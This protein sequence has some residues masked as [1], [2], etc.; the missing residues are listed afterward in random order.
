MLIRILPLITIIVVLGCS[1]T[2]PRGLTLEFWSDHEAETIDIQPDEITQ[3]RIRDDGRRPAV[4]IILNER[5]HKILE[6]L[7]RTNLGKRVTIKSN[8]E[9]LFE[10]TIVVPINGGDMALACSSKDQAE[11]IIHK[12]GRQAVYYSTKPTPEELEEAKA[13]TE[14][15]KDPWVDK[16]IEADMHGDYEKAEEYARKAIELSPEKPTPHDF[17]AI[18]YHHQGRKALALQEALTAEKLSTE[19]DL[20]RFPGTYLTIAE[21]YSE[22]EEYDKAIEYYK[23]VL[24]TYERN[25]SA[26]EGLARVYESLCITDSAITEYQFLLESRDDYIQKQGSEGIERLKKTPCVKKVKARGRP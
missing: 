6:E 1:T 3:V 15:T 4:E 18:I 13:R 14:S 8:A 2:T 11:A 9:V 25:F 7:T 16:A 24:S 19:E 20:R 5:Y 12:M 22:L 17:L 21:F 26:H 23:K 10:G